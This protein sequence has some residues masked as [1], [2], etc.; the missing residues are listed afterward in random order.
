MSETITVESADGTPL[1]ARVSGSGP[2]MVLV[3]GT[4]ND[5]DAWAFVEP[6]LAEHHRVWAFDRRGRGESGDGDEYSLEREAD[7]VRA[8]LAATGD[9]RP[10]LVGHSFGAICSLEAALAGPDLASLTI[11]EPPLFGE[12]VAASVRRTIALLHE[13][14][15]EDAA[16]VF[17]PE[18][19]G[20]ASEELAMV[21][22]LPDVWNR[23]VDV[24]EATFEREA[25]VV[26][27]VSGRAAR[28]AATDAPVLHVTGGLTEHAVYPTHGELV[29]AGVAAEHATI[30]GQRHL[31]LVGA[32]VAFA[33]VVL[34]FTASH[35]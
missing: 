6:I 3:H 31:A 20:L 12:R 22:S 28:Y 17:L 11:Y 25:G 26:D 5:K 16:L 15:P 8:V 34:A 14:N 35:P 24:A 13:G 1:V 7:D 18:V 2:A 9:D 33:E 23:I 21:R 30:E 29:E 10:H 27:T 4:T 19:A 32:P